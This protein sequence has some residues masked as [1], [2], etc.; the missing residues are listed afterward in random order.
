ML[1]VL[2]DVLF[3]SE[4]EIASPVD[5]FVPARDI[6]PILLRLLR[7]ASGPSPR[8][9]SAKPTFACEYPMSACRGIPEFAF[10]DRKGGF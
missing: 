7:N 10:W 5:R 3:Y 2:L 8:H 6:S 1:Y 4:A 9:R